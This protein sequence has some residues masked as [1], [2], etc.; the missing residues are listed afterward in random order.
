MTLTDHQYLLLNRKH[1]V[2]VL[3]VNSSDGSG[4]AAIAAYRL[5]KGLISQGIDSRL[6]VGSSHSGGDLTAV[7]PRQRKLEMLIGRLTWN[8]GFND[9]NCISSFKIPDQLFY[10]ETDILNFH[11]LHGG[12]F[13]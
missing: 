11:N 12:Y 7:I 10:K 2:K 9:L 5:H 4:G 6:L 1:I 3:H 13:N 8:L